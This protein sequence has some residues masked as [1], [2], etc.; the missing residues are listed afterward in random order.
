MDNNY[1]SGWGLTTDQNNNI[2]V[3]VGGFFGNSTAE[4]KFG[5]DTFKVTNATDPLVLVKFDSSGNVLFGSI[6]PS[7]GDDESGLAADQFGKIYLCGDLYDTNVVFGPDTIGPNTPEGAEWLFLAKWQPCN[8]VISGIPEITSSNSVRIF[9]NPNNGIFT[10]ALSHAELVSAS[11]PIVT[12][13]NVM[14]E[15]VYFATLNQVQGD[16]LINLSD[17]P[18]GI[19]F[20]RVLS[21]ADSLAGEGKIIIEK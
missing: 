10:I 2:Y 5:D 20:Y 18:N 21:D 16:N 12:I 19:Y 13:H 15:E 9:P 3:S 8:D 6:L 14:G 4:I 17:K 1:W 11:Q 7:G